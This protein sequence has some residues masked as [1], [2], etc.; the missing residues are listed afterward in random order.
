MVWEGEGRETFPYTDLGSKCFWYS[1]FDVTPFELTPRIGMNLLRWRTQPMHYSRV[2]THYL[3][4]CFD[5]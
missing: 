4:P 1:V 3:N 5:E 2:R